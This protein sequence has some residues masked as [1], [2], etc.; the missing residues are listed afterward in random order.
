MQP[1]RVA[2]SR[3]Q[4]PGKS[5][6]GKHGG[7]GRPRALTRLRRKALETVNWG[8][9]LQLQRLGCRIARSREGVGGV[10]RLVDGNRGGRPWWRKVIFQFLLIN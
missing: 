9:S 6:G 4:I 2:E 7:H 8:K 1:S 5:A 10:Q 3:I